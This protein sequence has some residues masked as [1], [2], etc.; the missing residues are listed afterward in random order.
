MDATAHL[1]EQITRL[2]MAAGTTER[3]ARVH[4]KIDTGMSRNGA[5][6]QTWPELCAAAA[7]A[8]RAGAVR[9]VGLWSHLASADEFG[10]P[11]VG[12]QSAAFGAASE[13]AAAAGLRPELRHLANSAGALLVPD[14]HLD[15]VRVGVAAYGIDPGPG[16]I[17]AA[18]APLRQVMRLRAQLVNV[19]D[20]ES[21]TGVSYG[22]TWHA[23]QSTRLGLVP[24]GYADG[25]PRIATHRA[26]VTV[27]GRRVPVRGR[28]CMDQFVV[29]LDG[30]DAAVGDEVVIFGPGDDGEPTVADWADWSETIGHEIVTGIGSRVERVYR[31][32]EKR[33]GGSNG[34]GDF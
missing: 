14:S 3:V 19:K 15:L 27:A 10:A 5:T 2:V 26:T 13:V 23:G 6:A 9:V 17:A 12:E 25:I 31:S 18:S 28:I 29:D 4:L 33:P 16:V 11:S 30:S 1:P 7:E 32:A 20:V 24:L 8:E 22:L 34:T 21:G